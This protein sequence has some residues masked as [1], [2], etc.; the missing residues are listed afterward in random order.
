MSAPDTPRISASTEEH[1]CRA[2]GTVVF[3][4]PDRERGEMRRDWV[5]GFAGIDPSM[6]DAK[7]RGELELQTRSAVKNQFPLVRLAGASLDYVTTPEKPP[8]WIGDFDSPKGDMSLE[9]HETDPAVILSIGADLNLDLRSRIGD[10]RSEIDPV[11]TL[12]DMMEPILSGS[13]LEKVR[14]TEAGLTSN[15]FI[16]SDEVDRTGRG[17]LRNLG[18]LIYFEP[19]QTRCPIEALAEDGQVRLSIQV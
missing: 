3:R 18:R 11:R 15:P 1:L 10:E 16:L 4:R 9:F 8:A 14:P 2:A 17:Q 12:Y 19:Y 7:I 6:P 13:G 5:R